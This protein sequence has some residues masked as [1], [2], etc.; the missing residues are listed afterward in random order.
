M[1]KK[2]ISSLISLAMLLSIMPYSITVSAADSNFTG[3][4]TQSDPYLISTASDLTILATLTNNAKD[5]T[6]AAEYASKYYQLTA[7]IDMSGVSYTPIS[8]ATSMYTAQGAS[9]TGT[10]DGNNHVI[11]NVT[12]KTA[13]TYGATYGIIGYLGGNGTVKNLGI[14]NM[15]VPAG[16]ASRFCIGGIAGTLANAITI[17]NSYVR[18]MAVTAAPSGTDKTT[19]VGGIAGRTVGNTGIIKNAYATSLNFSGVTNTNTTAGIL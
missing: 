12:M 6:T 16:T 14:E 7:D 5:K 2:L 8:W 17:E 4:G 1:K 10:L 15:T 11:K 18:G 13:S 9:F 19:Y 3:S